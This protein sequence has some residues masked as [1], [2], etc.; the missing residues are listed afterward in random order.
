MKLGVIHFEHLNV[1]GIRHHVILIIQIHTNCC[2]LIALLI[3]PRY[4]S[5]DRLHNFAFGIAQIFIVCGITR[6]NNFICVA[7]S[8]FLVVNAACPNS[9]LSST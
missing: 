7:G 2:H 1:T 9:M 5:L 4:C 6:V 8:E 3:I